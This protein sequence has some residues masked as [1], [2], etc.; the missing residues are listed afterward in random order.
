MESMEVYEKL[1]RSFSTTRAVPA[2]ILIT[3]HNF[4]RLHNKKNSSNQNRTL[5]VSSFTFEGRFNYFNRTVE[6]GED[7]TKRERNRVCFFFFW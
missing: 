5:F 6:K 2:L 1:R 3:L 4:L 7:E